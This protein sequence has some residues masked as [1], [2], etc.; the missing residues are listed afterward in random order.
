V[1]PSRRPHDGYPL[2]GN[3]LVT[4]RTEQGM[5]RVR[6]AQAPRLALVF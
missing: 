6:S 1:A 4:A 5:A 3:F 2:P